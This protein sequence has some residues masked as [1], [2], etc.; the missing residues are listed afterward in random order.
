M[1]RRANTAITHASQ[2]LMC[3]LNE[4]HPVRSECRIFKVI[5]R[6][7]SCRK[8][9]KLRVWLTIQELVMSGQVRIENAHKL[10]TNMQGV[11]QIIVLH[12]IRYKPKLV[13]ATI[14]IAYTRN[15]ANLPR[16]L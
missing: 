13:C 4:L 7:F 15:E 3:E 10:A 9:V 12:L 16:V 8:H 6:G 11:A 14:S 1:G 2:A 5:L